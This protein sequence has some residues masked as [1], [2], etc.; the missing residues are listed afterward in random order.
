MNANSRI[1][2]EGYGYALY[3]LC[4]LLFT[5]CIMWVCNGCAGGFGSEIVMDVCDTIL[6]CAHAFLGA[7]YIHRMSQPFLSF[8]DQVDKEIEGL[9]ELKNLINGCSD[10]LTQ[11]HTP[12]PIE[13]LQQQDMSSQIYA[14]VIIWIF[15][16]GLCAY[17]V[18]FGILMHIW[19]ILTKSNRF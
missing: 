12:G 5:M 2:L 16:V 3:V 15:I 9:N 4:V 10:D 7:F 19:Y 11:I 13:A 17:G 1:A 8:P 14:S 18:F 6:I